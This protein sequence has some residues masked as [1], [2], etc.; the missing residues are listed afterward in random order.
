MKTLKKYLII[1]VS[2]SLLYAC[3]DESIE[4]TQIAPTPEQETSPESKPT[5]S[6]L[7]SSGL[8]DVTIYY[9]NE[10]GDY[11]SVDQSDLEA[12]ISNTLE[13]ELASTSFESF[14]VLEDSEG[15]ALKTTAINNGITYSFGIVLTDYD[16]GS[17]VSSF[18]MGKSCSCEGCSNGCSLTINGSVCSCSSC[19][20]PYGSNL[21]C[22]KSET[23]TVGAIY[24]SLDFD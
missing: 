11:V 12:F 9:E 23:G 4:D 17:P 18:R 10:N 1:L 15:S 21:D 5:T 13:L 6:N 2:F 8:S 22:T 14:V 24:S 7:K 3:Q 19:E 20:L 16:D